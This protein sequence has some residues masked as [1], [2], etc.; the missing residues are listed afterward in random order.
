MYNSE[1]VAQQRQD[2]LLTSWLLSSIIPGHL[3]QFVG[4]EFWK[5]TSQ[6]FVAQ[7]SAKVM[8]LKFQL[9]NLKKGSL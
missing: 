9:Q 6:L 1:Y 5:S 8:H 4:Y 2:Q 7:S 3:P